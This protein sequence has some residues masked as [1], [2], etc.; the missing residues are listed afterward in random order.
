MLKSSHTFISSVSKK[1]PHQFLF[2]R[3]RMNTRH[4]KKKRKTTYARGS[5]AS[6]SVKV[7]GSP[8]VR[9]AKSHCSTGSTSE[10]AKE[11]PKRPLLGV[12]GD[13]ARHA[14]VHGRVVSQVLLLRR[15]IARLFR[16]PPPQVCSGRIVPTRGSTVPCRALLR[17]R[18]H[19]QCSRLGPAPHRCASTH[20]AA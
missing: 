1:K 5:S 13:M 6:R 17:T 10:A 14:L 3:E 9:Q 11:I 12:R 2:L 16:C 4:V 7:G 18:L 8:P 15:S 19:H 20:C